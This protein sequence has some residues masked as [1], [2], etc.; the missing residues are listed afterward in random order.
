MAVGWIVACLLAS[1]GIAVMVVFPDRPLEGVGAISAMIG[2]VLVVGLVRCRRFE[3]TIVD[4]MVRFGTGPFVRRASLDE[5]REVHVR[6]AT[7]L[8]RLFAVRE[9]VLVGASPDAAVPSASPDSLVG[10]LSTSQ[11]EHGH[12]RPGGGPS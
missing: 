6:L 12:A 1:G 8:R 9:V 3:I 10:E 2:I 4:G 5:V 11:P 7:G